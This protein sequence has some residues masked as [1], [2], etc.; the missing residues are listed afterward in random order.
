MT[1]PDGAP[2][3]GLDATGRALLT[4]AI[5]GALVFLF[6]L[7]YAAGE[8]QRLARIADAATA[9]VREELAVKRAPLVPLGEMIFLAHCAECHGSM[10]EGGKKAPPLRSKSFLDAATDDMLTETIR[11]G[12]GKTEMRAWGKEFGGPFGDDEVES[13]LAFLRSWEPDAPSGVE[14]P[15][16]Q[17]T[18]SAQ[19][20]EP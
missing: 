10:G 11:A 16:Q 5:L 3:R 9:R 15:R 20:I 18:V 14:D 13:L 17:G 19:R 6:V 2:R 8:R 12:R 1:A 7:F 4:T